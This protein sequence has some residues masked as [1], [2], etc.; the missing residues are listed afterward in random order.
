VPT[1]LWF[2]LLEHQRLV[3]HAEARTG[4]VRRLR[5]DPRA[6]VSSYGPCCA[7]C[8]A[9]VDGRARTSSAGE[10]PTTSWLP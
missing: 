9:G 5:H 8:S 7:A 6:R 4:T 1:P 2:S 10:A 3:L